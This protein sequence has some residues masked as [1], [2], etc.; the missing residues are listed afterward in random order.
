MWSQV[1]GYYYFQGMPYLFKGPLYTDHLSSQLVSLVDIIPSLSYHVVIFF[2]INS[3]AMQLL[4]QLALW[5][6]K[7]PA[8]KMTLFI[9]GV[10]PHSALIGHWV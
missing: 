6:D 7:C 1:G 2:L 10:M 3:N 9:P 5:R 4:I 8:V